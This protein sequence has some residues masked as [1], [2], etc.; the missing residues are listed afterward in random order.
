MIG[1]LH[2]DAKKD[3]LCLHMEKNVWLLSCMSGSL[4]V[5]GESGGKYIKKRINVGDIV[6]VNI[7]IKDQKA[8]VEFLVNGESEK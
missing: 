2:P 7:E 8:S 1:V 6:T 3:P 4:Y 5:H